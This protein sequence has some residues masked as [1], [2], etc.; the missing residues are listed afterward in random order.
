MTSYFLML[1]FNKKSYIIDFL[2]QGQKMKKDS[3]FISKYGCPKTTA[4]LD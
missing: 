2:L 4:I 3:L 1:Y